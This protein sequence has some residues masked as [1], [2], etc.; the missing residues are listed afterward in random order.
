MWKESEMN[1]AFGR[2]IARDMPLMP[3]LMRC[4]FYFVEFMQSYKYRLSIFL[5]YIVMVLI[6]L[7]LSESYLFGNE[8]ISDNPIT[9]YVFYTTATL[10]SYWL[11]MWM[12]DVLTN[13]W[14][15]SKRK[16]FKKLD[17]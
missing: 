16:N 1:D 13:I 2:R 10:M 17:N 12:A 14:Y 4:S 15:Y 5:T 3:K 6:L 8:L 7:A 11:V 9:P